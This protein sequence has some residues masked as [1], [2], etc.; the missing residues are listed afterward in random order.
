MAR[1]TG[2]QSLVELIR[3]GQLMAGET[4]RIRRRSA[5]PIEGRLDADGSICVGGRSF[6][7]PSAAARDAL[8]LRSADGWLRWHVPRL[9]DRSL[10]EIREGS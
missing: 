4:M 3:Q 5:R 1:T 8:N 10:A 9:G 6:A 7:T 2:T